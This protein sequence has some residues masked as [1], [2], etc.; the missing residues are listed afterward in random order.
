MK[1]LSKGSASG[2]S[3]IELIVV[4]VLIGLLT[5]I[6]T[7]FTISTINKIRLKTSAKEIATSLRYARSNAI[8]SKKPYYFYIDLNR[9]AYWISPE[10]VE[11]NKW[12][13]FDYEDILKTATK[14]RTTS[15]EIVIQKVEVG[16]SIAEKG[17]VVIPF[18]PQGG[19]IKTIVSLQ[20]KKG[21]HSEKNYEIHLDEV[22]GRVKIVKVF[23]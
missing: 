22:T 13:D 23:R 20:K 14:I 3:L 19:T 16:T 12:G 8:T 9:S 15:K 7:P 4:L 17:I 18:Y 11:K 21:T 5:A 6:V 2:Y 10:G 1:F